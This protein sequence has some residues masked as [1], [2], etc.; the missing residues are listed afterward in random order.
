MSDPATATL[1]RILNSQFQNLPLKRDQ[2]K[3]KRP[4]G[5]MFSPCKKIHD[6][7]FSTFFGFV[8]HLN[9]IHLRFITSCELSY[10]TLLHRSYSRISLMTPAPTVRPPSRIANRNSFSIA[11]GVI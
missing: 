1:T 5:K 7:I 9:L 3:L 10:W 6:R 4:D 11:I 8:F 2:T